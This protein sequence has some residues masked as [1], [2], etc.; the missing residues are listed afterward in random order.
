MSHYQDD[1][2][3][4]DDPPWFSIDQVYPVLGY[5]N[6]RAAVRAIRIGTFP[7]PTYL[8]GRKRVVDREVS[9]VFF[10][11]HRMQGLEQLERMTQ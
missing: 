5:R 4:K 1:Y 3:Y 11:R 8:I 6:R 2:D 10:K 7:L 9:L